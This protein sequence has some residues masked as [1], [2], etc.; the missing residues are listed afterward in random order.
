MIDKSEFVDIPG[1]EGLYAINRNGDI[2]SYYS[3]KILKQWLTLG[4]PYITLCK[5]TKKRKRRVARLVALT[6][7][8]NPKN[9]P[10][11]NHKNGIKKDNYIDNLEWVTGSENKKHAY[12]TGL[13]TGDSAIKAMNMAI[14]KL[15]FN[16]ANKIKKLYE[17]GDY[18]YRELGEMFN[19]SL[20]A[21]Y[22]VVKNKAYKEA[23]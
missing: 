12:R 15:S 10:E 13:R 14:R 16:D 22:R 3:G 2:W 23:V 6:F 1:Y 17:T 9:K 20:H 4:Y 7:I 19:V 18:S 5:E 21:I 11:V 8:P